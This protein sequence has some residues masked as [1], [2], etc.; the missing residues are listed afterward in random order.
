MNYTNIQKIYRIPHL[1]ELN[2][3]H[4]IISRAMT[5][6]LEEAVRQMLKLMESYSL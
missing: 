1:V 2:I 5:T 4:S 6:G 3:G